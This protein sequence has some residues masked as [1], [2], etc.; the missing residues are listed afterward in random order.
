MTK[1]RV[2]IFSVAYTPFI[3]G[4]EVALKELTVRLQNEFE[5]ELITVNLD[6]RQLAE[7]VLAGVRVHRLGH[8]PAAKYLFFWTAYR[9]AVKLAKERPVDLIWAMMASHNA[10]AAA[11]FKR[12]SPKT[13]FLLSLQEGDEIAGWRYRLKLLPV[14][15][16]RVFQLAD[17]I[18]AISNYLAR[19]AKQMGAV[20]PVVVIPNGVDLPTFSQT[21][22]RWQADQK[23][24]ITTSRLVAKNGVD[25]LIKSLNFLPGSVTLKILGS[26]PDETALRQLVAVRGLTGR[27]T[28]LGHVPQEKILEHL[29]AAT[30]FVRPSRSEGLGNSFLEAMAAGIPVIGTPVGGIPD[31]L[32]HGETGWLCK[33][34]DPQSIADQVN[35]ILDP[36]N[37]ALVQEV[38]ARAQELVT[39]RYDWEQLAKEMGDVLVQVQA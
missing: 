32:I 37:Q 4:A 16:L 10:L 38:V 3:G 39:N 13:P 19:W 20:C 23:V 27:V 24:L 2:L 34:D 9:Y 8:S 29:A 28:F 30:I 5:F 36:S 25:V 6:G 12:H 35:I 18:Q 26:G 17:Y 1:R 21:D 31:F 14:R 11:L 33:V 15:L 22:A 7:E